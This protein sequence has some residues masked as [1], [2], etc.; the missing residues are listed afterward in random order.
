MGTQL[1]VIYDGHCGVCTRL[2]E[3]VAKLDTDRV[4]EIVGPRSTLG[5]FHVGAYA[6]RP[7]GVAW[8]PSCSKL[9]R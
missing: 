5:G 7:S 9:S 4:L 3:R 2:A 1:T 8:P 6:A